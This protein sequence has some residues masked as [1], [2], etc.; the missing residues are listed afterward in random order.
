[1]HGHCGWPCEDTTG[2]AGPGLPLGAS[3]AH[4]AFPPGESECERAGDPQG[5]ERSEEYG[6]LIPQ[7][8]LLLLWEKSAPA[9]CLRDGGPAGI[10]PDLALTPAPRAAPPQAPG[11]GSLWAVPE[12]TA[13]HSPPPQ[14]LRLFL[15]CRETPPRVASRTA[16]E[17]GGGLW[18]AVRDWSGSSLLFELGFS[19]QVGKSGCRPADL[20]AQRPGPG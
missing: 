13:G 7:R 3:L 4:T 5:H 8:A 1:M 2:Q 9:V 20:S 17:S 11:L 16:Y 6:S 15:L 18:E 19:P 14:L 12:V 10:N